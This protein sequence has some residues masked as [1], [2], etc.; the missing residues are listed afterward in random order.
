MSIAWSKQN[1]FV[2]STLIG[3]NTVEQFSELIRAS[4]I[5]LTPDTLS[6]IDEVSK[7]IPYPMG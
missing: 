1:D 2:A 7:N 3:A 4:N 6:R 5:T